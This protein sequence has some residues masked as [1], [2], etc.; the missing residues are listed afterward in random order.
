M[1]PIF[2]T[3]EGRAVDHV[4]D[5]PAET[6]GEVLG[7]RDLDDLLLGKLSKEPAG[8][9]PAGEL[10]LRVPRRKVDDQPF[11]L[12]FRDRLELLGHQGVMRA[13]DEIRPYRL[14]E[15]QEPVTRKLQA[16]LPVALLDQR[17]QARLLFGIEQV[18][19]ALGVEEIVVA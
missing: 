9:Q 16:C 3:D 4:P 8:Q 13:R 10:G 11:D 19:V 17:K 1:P 2:I 7:V 5:A 14:H 12:T 15:R 6:G 18:E